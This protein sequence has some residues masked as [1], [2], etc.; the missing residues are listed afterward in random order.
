VSKGFRGPVRPRRALHQA[1]TAAALILGSAALAWASDPRPPLNCGPD[2][3]WSYE[4]R[5]LAVSAD[6]AGKSADRVPSPCG[7]SRIM[8]M[9]SPWLGPKDFL[10]LSKMFGDLP[11]DILPWGYLATAA[12]GGE[13]WLSGAVPS[14]EPWVIH[15]NGTRT[16]G[17]EDVH[18]LALSLEGL[19]HHFDGEITFQA[20]SGE[21]RGVRFGLPSRGQLIVL[22]TPRRCGVLVPE[23]ARQRRF[24][25]E[26]GVL[27]PPVGAEQAPPA[28]PVL[29]RVR[30]VQGPVVMRLLIDEKGQTSDPLVLWAPPHEPSLVKAAVEA[31]RSWRYR[32]AREN[33]VPVPV[34]QTVTMSF[35]LEPSGAPPPTGP[36]KVLEVRTA[37]TAPPP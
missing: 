26:Q 22:V 19:G 21:T 30:N 3:A 24:F 15:F 13:A 32:P 17:T 14:R 18:E 1:S 28:Y 25:A 16:E 31:A 37:P 34:F 8:P 35:R 36:K 2:W 5:F 23:L 7:G 4:L 33:G 9:D 6:P 20:R 10:Q 27:T 29:A 12:E 11:V